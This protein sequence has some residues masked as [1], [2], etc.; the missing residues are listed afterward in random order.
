MAANDASEP[1][2]AAARH[3]SASLIN[4]SSSSSNQ[5]NN[6]IT[7]GSGNAQY[8]ATNQYFNSAWVSS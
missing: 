6:T 2:T 3:Y 7:G 4:I 8:F 1:D 5:V